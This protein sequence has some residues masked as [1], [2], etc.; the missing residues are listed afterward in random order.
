[1]SENKTVSSHADLLM[2]KAGE[3]IEALRR[4]EGLSAELDLDSLRDYSICVLSG[5]ER[6]ARTVIYYSPKKESFSLRVGKVPDARFRERLEKAWQSLQPGSAG[7]GKTRPAS[8]GGEPVAGIHVF[9][10]GSCLDGRVG[11]GAVVLDDGQ[12][13]KRLSGALPG[14]P[15]GLSRQVAGEIAAVRES[16]EWC[17]RQGLEEV[18]IHY[19]YQGLEAWVT[20]RY[21]A[22]IPLTRDYRD[23]VRRSGVKIHWR[24][25]K[26][27]SG[28]RWND[29]ADRLARQGTSGG[30]EGRKAAPVSEGP[31][32][33]GAIARAREKALQFAEFLGRK[34]LS[35]EFKG[36]YN[37]HYAR[38]KVDFPPESGS[39][40]VYFDL[41]NTARRRM[42]PYLHGGGEP[43]RSKLE[44]LWRLFSG[45]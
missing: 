37:G 1:M 23:F 34:E 35:A 30:T 9:V 38:L 24:K 45:A 7:A 26:S 39:A 42:K 5:G 36:V 22:R 17:R 40:T 11:Y 21:R 3:Y 20:G 10:D 12:V 44:E 43:Q 19:D 4:E 13:V 16:L 15:E 31:D 41:Y 33:S 2:R 32:V 8:A 28:N 27:H 18:F 29:E 6:P 25:V 14:T